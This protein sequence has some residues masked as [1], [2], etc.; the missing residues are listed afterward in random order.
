MAKY[1]IDQIE[2]S[3]YITGNK[4][5][6]LC[7]K[8]NIVFSK[9]DYVLE[10]LNE[11]I[12]RKDNSKIFVTHQSDYSITKECLKYIPENIKWFAENCEIIDNPNIVGIPLGL[13][14]MDFVVSEASKN[15]RYSSCFAHVADFHK[16]LSKQFL[17]E[18]KI[19]NLV[20]MNFTPDTSFSERTKVFHMF[21]DKS[22]V[23]KK[24]K[25]P[26]ADFARDVYNHSFVLS[27]RGNGVDCIR[28]WES[29]YLGSI[30]IVKKSNVMSHFSDLPIL[31][32][33]N[34]EE[35]NKSLLE[36]TLIEF[37]NK[38][39]DMSKAKISYWDS[40]FDSLIKN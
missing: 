36:S 16:N 3:E 5:I 10:G 39:F 17:T 14:N 29:I 21:K 2:E 28:T 24:S 25:I 22:Y 7:D 6:K 19:E 12:S 9:T 4:F 37:Q 30:P 20:Y 40:L 35:I 8:Y 23:T 38:D 32:V 18:R 13:E 1:H 11:L 33:D 26:H 31:F 27:P 15:G 34:W